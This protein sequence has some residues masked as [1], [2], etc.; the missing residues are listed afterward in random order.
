M[1]AVAVF[2]AFTWAKHGCDVVDEFQQDVEQPPSAGRL[3]IGDRALQQMAGVVEFVVV[4]EVGPAFRELHAV[5][6]AVQ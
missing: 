3:E 2:L 5:A 1:T 4:A 6:V